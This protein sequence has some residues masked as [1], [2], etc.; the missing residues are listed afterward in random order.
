MS[1]ILVRICVGICGMAVVAAT[2]QI[3]KDE[4]NFKPVFCLSV[5]YLIGLIAILRALG[6]L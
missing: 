3:M 6:V 5:C 1:D 4:N 2:N